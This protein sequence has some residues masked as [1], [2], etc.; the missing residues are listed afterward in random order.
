[1]RRQSTLLHLVNKLC[2]TIPEVEGGKIEKVCGHLD[3]VCKMLENTSI[4]CEQ[5]LETKNPSWDLYDNPS[6]EDEHPL[7]DD[8]LLDGYSTEDPKLWEMVFD[9]PKWEENKANVSFDEHY[10]VIGYKFEEMYDRTM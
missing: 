7:D 9:D 5:D 6:I 4:V 2:S 1:M 10:R 3:H 8:E